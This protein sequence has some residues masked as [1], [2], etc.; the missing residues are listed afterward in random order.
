AALAPPTSE[1][2]GTEGRAPT[3]LSVHGVGWIAGEANASSSELRELADHGYLVISVD[4]ELATQDNATC[5][6]AHSQVAS[7]ATWIQSHAAKLVA[8]MDHLAFLAVSSGG[9]LVTNTAGVVAQRAANS[10][11]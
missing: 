9:N 11:R 4:Y 10:L 2:E 5:Q 7:A 8:D 1:P 6:S 3:F